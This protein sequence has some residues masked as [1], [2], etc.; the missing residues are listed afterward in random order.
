LNHDIASRCEFANDGEA[1]R[2]CQVKRDRSLSAIARLKKC[3]DTVDSNS[4]PASKVPET[5]TLD[6]DDVSTLISQQ[7]SGIGPGKS[8]RYIENPNSV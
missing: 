3:R 4:H 6:L 8:R 1:F 7:R 2:R 5:G